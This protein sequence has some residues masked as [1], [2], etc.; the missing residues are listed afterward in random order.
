MPYTLLLD[1]TEAVRFKWL[2]AY[3]MLI[4]AIY[5]FSVM[6]YVGALFD[7]GT[8][9]TSIIAVWRILKANKEQ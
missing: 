5:D 9:F 3:T 7:V 8:I 6:N 2:I 4:W 1:R